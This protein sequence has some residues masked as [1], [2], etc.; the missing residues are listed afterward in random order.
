MNEYLE[1]NGSLSFRNIK[2]IN[3]V[4]IPSGDT[5]TVGG[6]PLTNRYLYYDTSND[7]LAISGLDGNFTYAFNKVQADALYKSIAYLPTW[8]E[9]TGKPTLFSGAY[10]DLTGK[11]TLFNGTYAALTG[12]PTLFD[13][14]YSSLTGKPTL[15]SGDYNDLTNKPAGVITDLALGVPTATTQPITNSNGTGFSLQIA[16]TAVAGLLSAADKTILNDIPSTYAP[17]SGGTNYIQN[18]TAVDQPGGFRTAGNALVGGLIGLGT[19]DPTHPL[20]ISFSDATGIAMYNT[21]DQV[22]NYERAVISWTTNV[23]TIATGKANTGTARNINI[24]SGATLSLGGSGAT[25]AIVQGTNIAGSLAANTAIA[26][27]TT[28]SGF[29]VAGLYSNTASMANAIMI[30]NTVS[31]TGTGGYRG[32]WIT[33]YF[34]ASAGTGPRYLIDAGT[35]TALTAGGT[36]TSLFTLTN[37][38][39]ASLTGSMGFNTL[40]PTHTITLASTST[41][42]VNYATADQVTNYERARLSW[43]GTT[44]VIGVEASGTGTQRNLQFNANGGSTILGGITVTGFY[45]IIRNTGGTNLAVL[46]VSGTFTNSTGFNYGATIVTS[47]NQT[48]TA[49][50]KAL[51]I[52]TYEQAVGSGTR[53]LIDAGTNSATAGGGTHNS[54]FSV[55]SSGEVIAAGNIY[56]NGSSGVISSV[57]FRATLGANAPVY[58]TSS[59]GGVITNGNIGGINASLSMFAV[60]HEYSGS[61]TGSYIG[62]LVSPKH[63]SLG[64]GTN[65]LIDLGSNTQNN[66]PF[67]THTSVFKVSGSGVVTASGAVIAPNFTGLASNST[68][69]NGTAI[70]LTP[71]TSV[72]NFTYAMVFKSISNTWVPATGETLLTWLGLNTKR[73]TAS[74]TGS[75]TTISIPHGIAGVNTAT[76]AATAVA[77]N[78]ASA[79]ISYVTA[80]ATNINIF[81]T[82]APAAGTNNLLYTI[83]IKP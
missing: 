71:D 26:S 76:V 60:G 29:G 59:S 33:P 9:I 58:L 80:D 30:G 15:F 7:T 66:A 11:P 32:I 16:T 45:N 40:I 83:T 53:Y 34:T 22:T 78:A 3:S 10:A 82:V 2:A 62:I 4:A 52:S 28:A 64:S 12:K 50:Y 5:P 24:S 51:Y 41:G 20:T 61:G 14:V 25:R 38:G 75:A 37:L 68:L 1:T 72:N 79:G 44:F 19:P 17:I 55:N 77:N 48:G 67:S 8:T 54:V 47:Y 65:Y 69:W 21:T 18:Q 56:S 43:N 46:G 31:P 36:H 73:V 70:N 57:G 49:G 6:M 13:G 27:A 63:T 81:Y 42:Y 39:I 23:F 74:G 35:N